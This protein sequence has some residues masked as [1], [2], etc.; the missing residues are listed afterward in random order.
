MAAEQEPCRF[1]HI[2]TL[3]GEQPLSTTGMFLVLSMTDRTT[4]TE[5]AAYSIYTICSPLRT[6]ALQMVCQQDKAFASHLVMTKV[7]AVGNCGGRETT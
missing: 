4:R 3:K 1:S 7:K 5:R 2:W 6:H